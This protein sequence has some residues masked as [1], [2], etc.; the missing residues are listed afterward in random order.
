MKG[1]TPVPALLT[2]DEV[3]E[4]LRCSYWT[5]RSLVLTKQLPSVRLPAPSRRRTFRRGR[6]AGRTQTIRAGRVLVLADDL[7]RFI[8]RHR[9]TPPGAIPDERRR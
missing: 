7:A 1:S 4:Q 3:A 5:A 8:D 6:L 2:L 9:E